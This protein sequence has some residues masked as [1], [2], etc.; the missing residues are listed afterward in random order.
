M[1]GRGL[2]GRRAARLM[3]IAVVALDAVLALLVATAPNTIGPMLEQS[4]PLEWF[5]PAL[6]I[7]LNVGGLVWM[8]WIVRA[9]PEAS[10]SAWRSTRS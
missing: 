4:S 5:V 2:R 6:G 7:A 1:T 10:P 9:D 3:L 8:V